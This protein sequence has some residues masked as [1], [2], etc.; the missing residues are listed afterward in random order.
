MT[1]PLGA[2]RSGARLGEALATRMTEARVGAHASLWVR[3]QRAK[4]SRFLLLT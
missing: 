2:A 1:D 3:S 4:A